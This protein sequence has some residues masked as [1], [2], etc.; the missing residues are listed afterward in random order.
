MPSRARLTRGDD[1]EADTERK[2]RAAD[3]AS[4]HITSDRGTSDR[5]T[6]DRGTSDRGTSDRG[7]FDRGTSA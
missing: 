2:P 4:N 5:G 3:A 6:S 7:T 1:V